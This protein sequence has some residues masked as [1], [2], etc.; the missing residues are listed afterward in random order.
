MIGRQLRMILAAALSLSAACNS[1]PRETERYSGRVQTPVT[2]AD[3]SPANDASFDQEAGQAVDS[4]ARPP[5]VVIDVDAARPLGPDGSVWVAEGAPPA[6]LAEVDAGT[7]CR[8]VSGLDVACAFS[9]GSEAGSSFPHGIFCPRGRTFAENCVAYPG[10]LDRA[11]G[12]L[13]CCP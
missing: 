12:A 6:P 3:A 8:P 5:D 10:R 7:E 4:G 2:A 11:P 9:T 13:A 1:T